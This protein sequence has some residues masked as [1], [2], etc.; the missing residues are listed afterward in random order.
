MGVEVAV[1]GEEA[2]GALIAGGVIQGSSLTYGWLVSYALVW[3]KYFPGVCADGDVLWNL[4]LYEISW[5]DG[6]DGPRADLISEVSID[7]YEG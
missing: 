2:S 7:I 6:G 5:G 3:D 1:A 4:E